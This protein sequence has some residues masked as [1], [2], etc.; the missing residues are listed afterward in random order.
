MPENNEPQYELDHDYAPLGIVDAADGSGTTWPEFVEQVNKM[1][2]QMAALTEVCDSQFQMLFTG[3]IQP[4]ATVEIEGIDAAHV[5]GVKTNVSDNVFQVAVI[6]GSINASF[7][8]L[9]K[10]GG[11]RVIILY[12]MAATIAEGRFTFLSSSY[13]RW[14]NVALG[15]SPVLNDGMTFAIKELYLIS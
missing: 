3:T 7:G 6:N 8:G 10:A 2:N 9:Q 4:D 15:K 13:M 14:G 11:D 5:L 12:D 1:D